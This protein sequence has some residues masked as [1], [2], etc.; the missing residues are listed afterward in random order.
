MAT[1][2]NGGDGTY[3]EV[4]F[5]FPGGRNKDVT[6]IKADLTRQGFTVK[7]RA[8]DK[9]DVRNTDRGTLEAALVSSHSSGRW[10]HHI[11]EKRSKR[12][13]RSSKSP[14]EIA[15]QETQKALEYL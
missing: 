13:T 7:K 9:L 1:D 8:S 11:K 3:Y 15:D 2:G 10:E 14:L 4:T 5:R 12:R 6:G